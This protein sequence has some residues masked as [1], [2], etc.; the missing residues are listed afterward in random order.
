MMVVFHQLNVPH[1]TDGIG[2]FVIY[3]VGG[4][5]L[6]VADDNN[7]VTN[8]SPMRSLFWRCRGTRQ[9]GGV[10]ET[11]RR[12]ERRSG[13][14]IVVLGREYLLNSLFMITRRLD[15]GIRFKYEHVFI[16]CG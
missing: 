5:V 10:G 4:A 11:R 15:A 2:T 1:S 12:F 14:D 3:N 13:S 9:V 16:P 7:G 8:G 6:L